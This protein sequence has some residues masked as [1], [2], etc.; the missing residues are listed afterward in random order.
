MRVLFTPNAVTPN[1]TGSGHNLRTLAL[2]RTVGELSTGTELVVLLDSLQTTFADLF[3]H[4]GVEVHDMARQVIDHAAHNHLTT[5]VS[6]AGYVLEYLLPTFLDTAKVLGYMARFRVLRPD[7]VVSDCN[8]AGSTAAAM[9]GIPHVLVT[10][11]Y[12]FSLG[13]LDD[14]TLADT[15]FTVD[16]PDLAKARTALRIVFRWIVD[17]ACLVLTDKPY[18]PGLDDGTPVAVALGS[19][20]AMFTG[21]MV[22]RPPQAVDHEAVRRG[23]GLGPGPVIV[24]SVD[25][26]TMFPENKQRLISACLEAFR[27]LRAERPDLQLV[28]IGREKT[29]APPPG[30]VPVASLPEWMPLLL[31]ADLLL[32]APEWTTVTEVAMLRVPTL[33]VLADYRECHKIEALR[34]LDLLGLP[35]RVAPDPGGLAQEIRSLL[36]TR[37]TPEACRGYDTLAPYG[38]G[39]DDAAAKIVAELS[40]SSHVAVSA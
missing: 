25:G 1:A 36:A 32:T 2:A 39:T 17:D 30:V 9:S 16:V 7:L 20:K 27:T 10:E 3:R 12:D 23:L 14:G 28:L 21:P 40:R 4:A 19:G 24:A 8:T 34:R 18:I 38:R 29:A 13:R 31:T 11:R 5:D 26:T 22:R 35:T 15:G 33:F 37:C 6:W